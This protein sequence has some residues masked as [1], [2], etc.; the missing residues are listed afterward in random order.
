MT[1]GERERT[2]PGRAGFSDTGMSTA[3]RNSYDLGSNPKEPWRGRAWIFLALG[4]AVTF[5]LWRLTVNERR[6][7]AERMTR[8]ATAGVV[9]DMK[10]D[11]KSR[12]QSLVFLAEHWG[13]RAISSEAEWKFEAGRAL[14]SFP[15][16]RA[17]EWVDPSFRILRTV[18]AGAGR[19]DATSDP[20]YFAR[21]K[22]AIEAA[23]R[24]RGWTLSPTLELQGGGRGFMFCVPVYRGE[25]LTGFIVAVLSHR[26]FWEDVYQDHAGLGSFHRLTVLRGLL[27]QETGQGYVSVFA[28]T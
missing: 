11:I 21:R 12:M 17:F 28:L 19:A 27:S 22:V 9:A 25:R 20:E 1:P 18:S 10:S 6:S 23:R 26:D 13:G 24:E 14:N 2:Y 15:G 5:A 7:S 8:I 4:L 3:F 16:F